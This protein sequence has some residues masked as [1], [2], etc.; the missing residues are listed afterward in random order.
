V[1]VGPTLLKKAKKFNHV[2]N[3]LERKEENIVKSE[4]EKDWGKIL[5]HG[6]FIQRK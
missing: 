1:K 4:T 3:I 5:D 6:T 2:S